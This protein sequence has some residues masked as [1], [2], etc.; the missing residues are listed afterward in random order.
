M[1]FHQLV[2]KVQLEVQSVV[3]QKKTEK[4][5]WRCDLDAKPIVSAKKH[6]RRRNRTSRLGHLRGNGSLMG[7]P[8]KRPMVDT[9]STSSSSSTSSLGVETADRL[10]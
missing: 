5:K 10:C 2:S 8:K 6:R 3:C 4:K 1:R 7:I 9:V